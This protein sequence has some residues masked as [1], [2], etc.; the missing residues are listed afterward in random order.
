MSMRRFARRIA[1][2]FSSSSTKQ[3]PR[4]RRSR[5][6]LETLENR[7]V[8][9][10]A[11][12][13]ISG[14]AFLDG[15]ANGIHDSAEA[16][17]PGILLNL[18]GTTDQG[19]PVNVNA[20]TDANGAY[21]FNNVLPGN[22]QLGA[23]PSEAVVGPAN[24]NGSSQVTFRVNG[25]DEIHRDV[26]FQGM[27]P[28]FISLRQ[29]LTSSTL[30]DFTF[31]APGSGSGSANTRP[32][33]TPTIKLA[34]GDLTLNKNTADTIIDLSGRFTDPDFTNS[35]I[36]FDTNFGP[37]NIELFDKTAP[38]TVANFF[39]YITSNRYDNTIFHRLV[40]G[41]VLQGGGFAFQASPPDLLDVQTDPAVQNEFGASNITGTL[42][43]AKLGNDPNSA[44]SQFFFNLADNT[45]DNPSGNNLD[46]LNGGFTVFGKLMGTADQQ[47]INALAA[48]PTQDQT[49]GAPNSPFGTIPL[50][51]YNGTS[52]P[53]DTNASNYEMINDVVVVRR[54]EFLTYS[55]VSNSDDTIVHASI[56]NGRLHLSPQNKIGFTNITIRATDR[57]GASVDMSFKVTVQNNPPTAGVVLNT[58]SPTTNATLTANVTASDL[59]SDPVTVTYVWKVNGNQVKTT[60]IAGNTS[61]D[62]LDLSQVGNGNKG[63]VI[64]VEVTPNDGIDDGPLATATATVAD[65]APTA[66]VVLSPDPPLTN[67]TLTATATGADADGDPVT[68]TYVWKVNGNTVPNTTDTLDLSQVGNGDKGQTI[69]VQVTPNDGTLSGAV[70]TASTTVANSAPIVDSVT[71][72][73]DPPSTTDTLAATVTSHDP[74]G[75]AVTLSFAWLQNGNPVAGQT[76]ATLDLS[77]VSG[78]ITGDQFS[79]V[80]TPNDGTVDGNPFTS[81]PVTVA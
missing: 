27:M 31:T 42:A 66:T 55:I 3:T 19:T 56:V 58:S 14:I 11:S 68:F 54:D 10:T 20:T 61:S 67:D 65:S 76:T 48:V 5:L 39:N 78:V 33:N 4:R 36:R 75:E 40:G 45:A 15:N 7:C 73:P 9:A 12:G 44:T 51:N 1:A 41:F 62:T 29:F 16:T 34:I 69:T 43:M 30:A 79:V 17:V 47:I 18:T 60:T 72:A 50:I 59:N 80:V 6:E 71:L 49:N 38:Q 26:G 63:D 77:T 13:T 24:A 52:F 35:Q 70:A 2:L 37:I 57:F 74:D 28:A 21:I 25:G 46:T 64:T 53:T 22:Y 32:N 81:N 23:T 8:P